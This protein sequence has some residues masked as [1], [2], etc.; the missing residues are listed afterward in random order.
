[1]S[2]GT[3][4]SRGEGEPP[5]PA[6][7]ELEQLRAEVADLRT[8]VR[9]EAQRRDWLLSLRRALAAVLIALVAV[10]TVTSV[11]GLWGARTTLNTDRWVATVAPLPRDPKVNAAVSAYLTDQVFSAVDV[12]RRLKR[13]LPPRAAFLAGPVTDSVHDYMR[14]SVSR[15]L[16]SD[17]FQDLWRGANRAAHARLVATLENKNGNVRVQGSTVTLNLLPMTN[18]L[19]TA[20][21]A[22]LPQLFGKKLDLPTL[23]SG[24][25]PPA[26]HQRIE[27]ALGVHLPKDFAQITLYD[28]H[29]L[30]QLQDAVLLFKR[31]LAGLVAGTVVLLG[32][33]LW[34]SPHRRRTLLQ[35]G[36][37][38]AVTVTALSAVL[39]AVRDQILGQ[40]PKGVY[41]DGV[42]EALHHLFAVLRDRADQLLWFGI[43][44]AVLMYAIGPG[45]L[46]SA[47]RH[48]ASQGARATGTFAA[49]TGKRLASAAEIRARTRAH[50][51]VLRVGGA[52]LAALVALLLSSWTGLLVVGA[53]LAAYEIAVTLLARGPD[54]DTAQGTALAPEQ[55]TERGSP[56]AGEDPVPARP[57]H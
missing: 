53:L 16:K 40:V 9:S 38:L 52:V 3:N 2:E 33:A 19:L 11:V 20:L 45:R 6:T 12:E 41:R 27:K 39:R 35:L 8:R 14:T 42:R 46:P 23:T 37:W 4:G 26:L 24:E 30:A 54:R 5:G 1:M 28:R 57:R 50:A 22:Q 56:T 55:G 10:C 13:A 44:L 36:L 49:A 7:T 48:G 18:N 31:G 17:S 32:L 15:L 51:D 43:A 25:L 34:A 21:E 29:Q 47:A